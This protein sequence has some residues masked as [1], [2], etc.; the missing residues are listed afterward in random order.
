ME[1]I[2]TIIITAVITLVVG[3]FAGVAVEFFKKIKPKLK[4][5]VKE[6]IPINLDGKKIGANVIEISNPSSKTVK[7]I[8]L[9]IRA[10]GAAVINSGVKTT[11]GLNYEII[12]SDETLEVK[13][14]FL[15]AKDFL[16][17]TTI[18]ESKYIIPNKP[19]VT[20]RSPDNFKLIEENGEPNR[21]NNFIVSLA[22]P[23]AL[24]A[25]TVVGAT[26]TIGVNPFSVN[27]R[28]EQGANLALS[29]A[30]VGLPNLASQYV[31]NDK[32]R[33][34]NQ[35]PYVY[36]LAKSSDDIAK[37]KLY[38]EFLIKTIEVSG[39]MA[40][41]SK[42]ALYFFIAKIHILQNEKKEAATWFEKSKETNEEEYLT[43]KDFF[44]NEK[45]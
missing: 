45:P 7:D 18:L 44:K 32:I 35:G 38:G 13:I 28:I 37:V 29:A 10:T 34:Y 27:A 39:V 41:S 14:P 42:S 40:S 16:S 8:V 31:S 5:S 36:S 15:K 22:I 1:N 21:K 26:L 19:D 9:K 43:L 4:Y 3:I 30:L 17:I 20:V 11:T 12:E 24:V 25:A 23:P 6:S 2:G 33:Y